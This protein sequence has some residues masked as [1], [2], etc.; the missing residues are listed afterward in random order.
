MVLKCCE[1]PELCKWASA[2]KTRVWSVFSFHNGEQMFREVTQCYGGQDKSNKH[3]LPP[4]FLPVIDGT[5]GR[6]I[7]GV[8]KVVQLDET[9]R[10]HQSNG[11]SEDHLNAHVGDK[12]HAFWGAKFAGA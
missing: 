6:I 8:R 3:V 12:A 9:D 4:F 7:T 2:I 5:R 10:C 11:F 1:L